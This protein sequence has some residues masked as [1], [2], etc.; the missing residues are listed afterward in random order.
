MAKSIKSDLEQ[1]GPPQLQASWLGKEETL[2]SH[3]QAKRSLSEVCCILSK[4]LKEVK[5]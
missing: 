3:K 4:E 1:D 2:P 5:L